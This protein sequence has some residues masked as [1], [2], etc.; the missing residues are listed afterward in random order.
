MDSAQLQER[1]PKVTLIVGMAGCGKTS[2]THRL[3][4]ALA[5]SGSKSYTVNLDPAVRGLPYKPNIDIRD[6][7][8]YAGIRKKYNLGPNGAILTAC[9]LFATR[10]DQVIS[11]CTKRKENVSN[12]LVDTPGQIEI[13][14]WSA[15]GTIVCDTFKRV[16]PTVILYVMD[17]P[18]VSDA[19]VFML[20]ML[21]C[22]SI[23][24]KTK[25]PVVMVYNKVDIVGHEFAGLWMKDLNLISSAL[26]SASSYASELAKSLVV[27]VSEFYS[28][29]SCVGVSA[30]NDE[31]FD[32]LLE[33]LDRI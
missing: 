30:L 8:D 31:G 17:T 14:T 21:Q 16:F 3:I 23:V 9:N 13:F 32:S 33:I 5:A 27:T 4:A 7:I 6:T 26:E 25:L 29:L 22:L 12:I 1:A 20:N 28:E 10:F 15:S 24:Y 11:L 19:Q 2:V 18:R